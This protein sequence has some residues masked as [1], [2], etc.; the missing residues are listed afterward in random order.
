MKPHEWG[1]TGKVELQGNDHSSIILSSPWRH[2]ED[3]IT[4]E[5]QLDFMLMTTTSEPS[6]PAFQPVF[7]LPHCTLTYTAPHQSVCE[8]TVRSSAEHL[9][10]AE[11]TTTA[12]SSSLSPQGKRLSV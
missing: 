12:L 7:S 1:S 4:P 9:T 11:A 6:I 8:D 3:R 2:T 10:K 5:I